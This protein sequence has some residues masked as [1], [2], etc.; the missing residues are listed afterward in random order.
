MTTTS[1]LIRLRQSSPAIVSRTAPVALLPFR[2]NQRRG[3][4]TSESRT[5]GS[6]AVNRVDE[7][8]KAPNRAP[9]GMPSRAIP[10]SRSPAAL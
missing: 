10:A 2:W 6:T 4:S 1:G 5:V 8:S 7:P 9:A 3:G